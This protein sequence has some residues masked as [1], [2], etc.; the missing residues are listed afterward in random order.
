MSPKAALKAGQRVNS[1]P[2]LRSKRTIK[3][4]VS[5]VLSKLDLANRIKAMLRESYALYIDPVTLRK[6]P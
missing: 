6:T 4:H 3:H 2:P 5:S 1:L